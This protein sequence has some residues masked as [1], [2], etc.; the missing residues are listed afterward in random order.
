LIELRVVADVGDQ[1]RDDLVVAL[2]I[3]RQLPAR[4]PRAEVPAHDRRHH[5]QPGGVQHHRRQQLTQ[6]VERGALGAEHRP[7]DRVEGDA[8]HRRHG[9]EFSAPGPRRG[10]AQ[11][12]FFDDPFVG[13]HPLAVERR[14]EKLPAFAV[15][16]AVEA[17]CRAGTEHLTE[18]AGPGNEVG[19]GGEQILD[20]GRVADHDGLPENRQP[21]CERRPVSLGQ[22]G[23]RF[24]SGGDEADAL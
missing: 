5:S 13:G 17:E 14:N 7:Q 15:L 11:H 20:Q 6:F 3:R 21:Q 1:P 9:F 10:L 2:A 22:C 23:H 18:H 16:G 19:V 24:L 4:A 8:H 12:L